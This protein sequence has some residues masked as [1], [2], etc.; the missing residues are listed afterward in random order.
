[1]IT[2]ADISKES[3]KEPREVRMA[4]RKLFKNHEKG[5]VWYFKPGSKEHKAILAELAKPKQPS[6]F[7]KK[8]PAPEVEEVV[9]APVI[10]PAATKKTKKK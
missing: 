6:P 7:V 4:L 9:A 1:M 5:K 8:A 3:G 10:A 2:P